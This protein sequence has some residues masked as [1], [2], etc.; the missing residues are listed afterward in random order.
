W[1]I[2]NWNADA[3]CASTGVETPAPSSLPGELQLTGPIISGFSLRPHD[4]VVPID[5]AMWTGFKGCIPTDHLDM[6]RAG[7]KAA[8]DLDIDLVPF[9]R[10][11][12]AQAT[13][14]QPRG[15]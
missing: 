12:A 5:S 11:L 15:R 3:L 14:S 8:R 10:Q 13:G 7:E 9:Y 6:T 1:G 4:G 2:P